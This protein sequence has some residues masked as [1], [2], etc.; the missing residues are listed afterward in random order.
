M[1]L[2]TNCVTDGAYLVVTCV[3]H[4]GSIRPAEKPRFRSEVGGSNPDR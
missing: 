2:S 1:Y 3:G 4:F